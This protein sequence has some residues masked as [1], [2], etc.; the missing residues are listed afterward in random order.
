MCMGG[1]PSSGTDM[2]AE[3]SRQAAEESRRQAEEARQREVDR[4]ARIQKGM[5]SI[6]SSLSGFNDDYYK[7]LT[8]NYLNFQLPD[9]DSQYKKAS[10][11]LIFGLA[12]TG[13]LR[14]SAGAYQQG[15]L[16]KEYAKQKQVVADAA[17]NYSR[18]ARSDVEGTRGQL[19]SQLN[20]TA[21]PDS[22]GATAASRAQFL[23][24]PQTINPLGAVFQNVTAAGATALGGNPLIGGNNSVGTRLFGGSGSSK[25]VV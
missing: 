9:L 11:N 4:Q 20:E 10:D 13:N 24:T 5:G 2:Q 16:A 19:V 18:Q 12:R 8:D 3:A 7:G 15:E 14:S 23:Q 25:V 6:D 21:D 22:I 1:A 17:A